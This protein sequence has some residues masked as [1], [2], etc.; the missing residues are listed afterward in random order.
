MNPG[1]NSAVIEMQG[2]TVSA[3]RD[4][5]R[6]VLAG[7]DWTVAPGEFWVVAGGQH[8][9]KTDLLMTAAALLPPLAGNCRVWGRETRDFGGGELTER[10]R[11]GLVFAGGQLFHELTLGENIA[12]PLAYH[13]NLTAAEAAGET[14]EL[15]E[16]LELTPFAGVLPAS[17]SLEWRKRAALARALVLQPEALLCDDPLSGLGSRH[18]QWWLQFLDQLARGHERFGGRPLTLVVTT[19]D[20]PPWQNTARRFAWLRDEKFLPLGAWAELAGVKDPALQ[21]LMAAPPVVGV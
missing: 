4:V 7:V 19:E 14:R 8:A 17:V 11:L 20:L 21:E 18:R 16:L 1:A 13:R 9:G 5:T 12:L 2:V 10:L 3:L 6:P 15:L